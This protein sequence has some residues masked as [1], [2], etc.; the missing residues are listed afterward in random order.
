VARVLTDPGGEFRVALP[1]E[2]Q[3]VH[4]LVASPGLATVWRRID[5]PAADV[6]VDLPIEGGRLTAT[7]DGTP[8]AVLVGEAGEL[9]LY[10]V[11][12]RI[13]REGAVMHFEVDRLAAGTYRLCP[14]EL[15]ATIRYDLCKA[16]AITNGSEHDLHFGPEQSR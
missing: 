7:F 1:D 10:L 4:L 11:A 2:A 14:V 8:G 12:D 5:L 13:G 16:L 3:A 6:A 9:G 15:P